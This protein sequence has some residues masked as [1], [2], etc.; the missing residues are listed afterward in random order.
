MKYRPEIDGLRAVA[1]V[2]VILFHAGFA[3]F[4]GGFVGVD[5]F[6]VISGY[7][8]TKIIIDELD[9]GR[10]SLTKFYERRARRIL[11]A[12]FLVMMTCI[13]FAWMWLTPDDLKSFGQS[14]AAVSLFSSNILFWLE[15]GYFD[16]AAELKPLL[17]TWSLAVEEQYYLLFPLFLMFTWSMGRRR[18]FGILS[19]IALASLALA[20]WGS[21]H[22]RSATFFLLPTRGWEL[23]VGSFV[24]YYSGSEQSAKLRHWMYEW[25]ALLGFAM[26]WY[27]VFCFDAKTPFPSV[28]ALLPT[29]GTALVIICTRHGVLIGKVLGTS[30]FVGIGLISYS[31]YLWHQPLFAFARHKSV[32]EP[33]ASVYAA[34]SLLA[35]ALAYATRRYVEKPV[36][37]KTWISSANIF[38]C[39]AAFSGLLLCAGVAGALTNGFVNRDKWRGLDDAFE[40]AGQ[41]GS[42]ER[43]CHA[44]Q[45]ESKLGPFVC[46]IGDAAKPPEGVLWGD[47]YAAALMHGLDAEL[48]MRGRSF[49]VVTSDGCIPLEGISRT[50]RS[51][52]GCTPDRHSSFIREFM[53]AKSLDKLVWIGAFGALTGDYEET[54]YTLDGAPTTP[55]LVK[56]RILATLKKLKEGGKTVVFVADAPTFPEHAVNPAIKSFNDGGIQAGVQKVDR[57]L[58]GEKYNQADLLAEARQYAIVVDPLDLLCDQKVCA[59]HAENQDLLYID[60]GHLSHLGS[61]MLGTEIVRRL[62]L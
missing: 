16:T 52:F 40:V 31:A 9:A 36:R 20:Q 23:F 25:G 37:D 7:L 61:A 41:R 55:P 6:F 27:G 39:A 24:A 30:A 50:V 60:T 1:V 54:D 43:F 5:V 19:I 59:S 62:E 12:L 53:Q 8:I 34:L 17:H 33:G 32:D 42:G 44:H 21:T 58:L 28:Y 3:P 45:I 35:L 14:V 29:L 26:I 2:P 48:K 38:K 18:V 51:E 11:P 22:E 47:S 57:A 4:S 15:S 13:P 49:Y 10:F 56:R 46:V